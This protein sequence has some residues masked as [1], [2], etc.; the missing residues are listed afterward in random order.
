[1]KDY[2][3]E[4]G[5][6]GKGIQITFQ[7]KNEPAALAKARKLL[8]EGITAETLASDAMIVQLIENGYCVYDYMN[9]SYRQR[10]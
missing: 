10:P 5:R 1:M 6:W 7:A 8:E 4:L 2:R 3:V 9:G